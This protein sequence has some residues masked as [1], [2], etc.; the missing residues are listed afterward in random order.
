MIR[1]LVQQDEVTRELSA[2]VQKSAQALQDRAMYAPFG[3]RWIV[4][5][6]PR[7]FRTTSCIV[8]PFGRID[9]PFG[10]TKPL[11]LSTS[12]RTWQVHAHVYS[13]SKYSFVFGCI[14]PSLCI[15]K[16]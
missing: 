6:R 8:A 1:V 11:S 13:P 9:A 5:F 4:V 3:T 14:I 2:C 16:S 12:P 15:L 10:P 7:K